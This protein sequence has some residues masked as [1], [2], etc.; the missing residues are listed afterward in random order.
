MRTGLEG[1]FLLR[2][3]LLLRFEGSTL[4][5]PSSGHERVLLDLPRWFY[6][7]SRV[8]PFVEILR[9]RFKWPRYLFYLFKH[10]SFL[11]PAMR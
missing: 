7:A 9:F 5:T 4:S 1:L 8:V 2:R 3:V 6:L 10:Y 11:A